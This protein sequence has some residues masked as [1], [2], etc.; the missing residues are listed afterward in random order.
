VLGEALALF[1]NP[2]LADEIIAA[3]RAADPAAAISN[4]DAEFRNDIPPFLDDEL[5]E[6]ATP[7]ARRLYF[8]LH[9]VQGLHRRGG[10]Y[11][12][13]LIHDEHPPQARSQFCD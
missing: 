12:Q 3:Q 9:F 10:R 13:R 5:I 2:T 11:R 6:A 7:A 4:W 8:V 1:F